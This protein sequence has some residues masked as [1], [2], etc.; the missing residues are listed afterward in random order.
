MRGLF[1]SL[2]TSVG[3]AIAALTSAAPVAP[4]IAP[5]TVLGAQNPARAEA[6][7]NWVVARDPF[8]DLWFHC[9][10]VIRYDGYGALGLYDTR[11]AD[12]V[13]DAKARARITTTL[14]QRA[15]E[16]RRSL[17]ADSAFEVLH[18]LPLYFVGKDPSV[19][20]PALRAA[21]H[22]SPRETY[23][24]SVASTAALIAAALP[25]ARQRAVLIALI[26]AANGE[27]T[28]FLRTDRLTQA[29]N[30]RQT[31]VALQAAWN[32]RFVAPLSA[33]LTATNVR[34]GTILISPAIGGEGR[35]VRGPGGAVI[36]A[37]GSRVG[38]SDTAPL[39][40]AVR[41]L[42]FPLLDRLRAPL[43]ERATRV[44]AAKARDAAAVRA[45]ALVLEAIDPSLAADYRRLFVALIG[46]GTLEQA[47]PLDHE[48][49][50]ELRHLVTSAIHGAASPGTSYENQ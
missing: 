44:T 18:F 34:R 26:D 29:A 13:K 25:T 4:Q 5:P 9:L 8:V 39:L 50:I 14:D 7:S 47:Y 46:G 6:A 42:S 28:S 24:G 1:G 33:Y 2:G 36:I 21:L 37:V 11:Y 43:V 22:D 45:G 41:E 49:E 31:V 38:G 35:I 23:A 3:L 10:A 32:D 40:A 12:R 15:V 20:L 48:A 17:A 19:V 16:L 27:W 30:D